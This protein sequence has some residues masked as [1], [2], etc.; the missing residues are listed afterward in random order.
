MKAYVLAE[1]DLP[2]DAIDVDLLGGGPPYAILDRIADG[3]RDPLVGAVLRHGAAISG[4]QPWVETAPG[5]TDAT[6]MINEGKIRTLVEFGPAGAFAH[7]PHEFVE[8]DQ[9]AVGAEILARTIV[10]VLG[11]EQA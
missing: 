8:R 6:V 3:A 4:F 2:A 9:I 5:G 11:V 1:T 10:D 7:E